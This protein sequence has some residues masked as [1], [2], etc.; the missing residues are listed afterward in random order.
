MT[1]ERRSFA[2]STLASGLPLA[3]RTLVLR[4]GSPG[5]TVGITAM[6]H[7]DE[8]EGLLILR[9]LWRAIDAANV[10][11][12]L[13]LVPVVNPLAFEAISR[14]TP[15]DMLDLN[16]NFPGARDGWLSEQMAFTMAS[17]FLDKIDVLIDIHAGG[18]FPLV[19]YCYALND[20]GLSRAF[21][22][23]LLYAPE[24]LYPGTAAGYATQRGVPTTVIEIGGGYRSLEE[25]VA[26]GVR[27]VT[28]M[29]RHAGALRGTVESRPGQRLLHDM[30]V[31]RPRN[32]GLCIPAGV[33]A[34]G[35]T[36][37]GGTKLADIVSPYDFD[38]LETM[39]APY[40]ESVVVLARNY[41]TRIQPGDYTFMMG[42][43][44]SATPY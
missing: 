20:H 37:A 15:I 38:T 2:V 42:D 9:E 26:R 35:A 18:T 19:D 33:L 36:I 3:L 43:G 29:L 7:G 41:A 24:Q 39:V 14:N 10:T 16:R 28:N 12:T 31:M 22:S 1:R 27:G 21:L 5:P 4:G 13:W 6:V 8:I 30:K 25:H 23:E 44:A 11:G 34:M 32:G 40:A 17:E